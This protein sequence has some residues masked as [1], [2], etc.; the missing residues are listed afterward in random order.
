[1]WR[2][3]AIDLKQV[4]PFQEIKE[5]IYSTQVDGIQKPSNLLSWRR[6]GKFVNLAQTSLRLDKLRFAVRAAT[7]SFAN[8]LLAEKAI[9]CE[10]AYLQ[11]KE[12]S[13]DQ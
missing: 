1:M 8:K 2:L 13:H 12:N 11:K 6:T 7:G 9:E 4:W 5:G 10:I 3:L